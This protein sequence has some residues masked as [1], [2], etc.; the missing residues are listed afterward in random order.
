MVGAS[1][2]GTI[3]DVAETTLGIASSGRVCMWLV[4]FRSASFVGSVTI[5]GKAGGSQF[6]LLALAYKDMEAGTN[7]TAAFTGGGMA[8][9]DATGLEVVLDCTSYTS[10]DLDY[11]AHPVVG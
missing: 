3:D 1:K 9:V 6:P 8:L 7:A 5:K 2:S 11:E 4:Q 10:G